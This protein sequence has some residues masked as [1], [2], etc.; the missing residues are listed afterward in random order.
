LTC[1][2]CKQYKTS[3]P[4]YGQLPEKV[5]VSNPFDEVLVDLIGPWAFTAGPNEYVFNALVCIDPATNLSELI[6][7]MN[8]ESAYI[9]LRF[10][11]EW[12]S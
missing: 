1:Q 11:D 4:G 7:I 9:A 2:E 6:S 5:L 3:G 8:K 10:E 12:L